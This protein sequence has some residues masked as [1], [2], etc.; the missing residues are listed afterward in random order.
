[1][2]YPLME[3]YAVGSDEYSRKRD[4][5]LSLIYGRKSE[6]PP[7]ESLQNRLVKYTCTPGLQL[8]ADDLQCLLQEVSC[9]E[10]FHL[11]KLQTNKRRF[12]PLHCASIRNHTKI[13]ERILESISAVNGFALLHITDSTGRTPLH[14]AAKHDNTGP[15]KTIMKFLA[16]PDWLTSLWRVKDDDGKKALDIAIECGHLKSIVALHQWTYSIAEVK[17]TL[18]LPNGKL[19]WYTLQF[20]SLSGTT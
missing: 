20:V 18:R 6:I 10:R 4:F 17:Q 14:C 11:L 3:E 16:T 15:I 1:M 12:T 2:S 19:I 9:D 8:K 7:A 13:T 5:D